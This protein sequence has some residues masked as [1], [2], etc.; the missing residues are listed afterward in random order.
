LLAMLAQDPPVSYAEISATLQIPVG[1]I[2]P[3]RARCLERLRK[4]RG[5]AA[6]IEGE[7]DVNWSGGGQRA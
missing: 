3:Q 6:L 7:V 5:V 2:G 4:S 1:S